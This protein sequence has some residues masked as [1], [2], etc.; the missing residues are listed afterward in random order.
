MLNAVRSLRWGEFL[1]WS[2]VQGADLHPCKSGRIA[3]DSFV[4]GAGHAWF[5]VCQTWSS[6]LFSTSSNLPDSGDSNKAHC[7][8]RWGDKAHAVSHCLQE[9]HAGNCLQSLESRS[10]PREAVRNYSTT[11]GWVL[12]LMVRVWNLPCLTVGI[13][14]FVRTS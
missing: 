8:Q 14:G 13:W 9:A 4:G 5:F 10:P 2:P 3:N 7:M 11:N 6:F 12:N 1:A